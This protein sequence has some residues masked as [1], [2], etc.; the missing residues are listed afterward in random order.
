MG[1]KKNYM[2]VVAHPDDEVL[3]GG[4]LIHSLIENKHQVSVCILTFQHKDRNK[5][6]FEIM[7]EQMKKA[8]EVLGVTQFYLGHFPNSKLHT[9]PQGEINSFIEQCILEAKP[10]VIITHHY[11]DLNIDHH[12]SSITSQ[13]AAR[14]SQ[15]QIF[16]ADFRI[17]ALYY[18]EVQS[19]TDWFTNKALQPFIPD[20]FVE[21]KKENLDAKIKALKCYDDVVRKHPHPRSP[22]SIKSLATIRGSQGGFMLAEAF[23]TAFKHVSRGEF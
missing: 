8:Y 15:R 13:V 5:G 20:T 12:V 10:N 22:E 11:S 4:G 6:S 3:G 16:D 18:M 7:Y 1:K 2:F 14:L 19:S 17:E 9:V 23:Q 21:I